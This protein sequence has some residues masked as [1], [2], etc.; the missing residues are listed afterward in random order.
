MNIPFY[1]DDD[2]I[3]LGGRTLDVV[4]EEKYYRD[5]F[6]R[7]RARLIHSPAFRR[8]RGKTQLFPN[9]DNDFFRCRLTHSL[10]V[11]TVAKTLTRRLN[12][13]LKNHYGQNLDSD[14]FI[15]EDLV[16][17]ACL[18]H[19]IGHPPFGH[20]GESLLNEKMSEFGGFEGNAQTLRIL[21]VLEKKEIGLTSCD[22]RLDYSGIDSEGQDL[23][24][25]LNLTSR[26]LAAILKYNRQIPSELDG[27]LE[28]GYYYHDSDIVMQIKNNVGFQDGDKQCIECQIM[29]IADDIAY[30]TY[31]LEDAFKGGFQ[32]PLELLSL[33]PEFYENVIQEVNT[34]YIC[35]T[36]NIKIDK[37]D[38]VNAITN[39]IYLPEFGKSLDGE[40]VK[41]VATRVWR[42]SMEFA[43]IG[44]LRN[45]FTS[46]AIS[47]F[48]GQISIDLNVDRPAFSTLKIQDDT[49][50]DIE[51]LKK[52]TYLSQIESTKLKMVEYRGQH[53]LARLFDILDS[54]SNRDGC[55][56]PNDVRMIYNRVSD[57]F[58]RKRILCDF[59]ASMTNRYAIDYIER[60]E[61]SNTRKSIFSFY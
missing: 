60:L 10:E 5:S 20:Q 36:K 6:A 3:R 56:L 26:S 58:Y 44:Y 42:S 13:E 49:I 50:K 17:F 31:D 54:K 12:W 4:G 7:D 24:F 1:T 22:D 41:D 57:D 51:I 21:S 27:K 33:N 8:L 59:I 61:S 37:E 48:I 15:N 35:E 18:A 55:L 30:S 40:S 16:E 25:G 19:D 34:S 38:I 46:H 53:L 45:R 9:R 28:K 2:H 14:Y 39:H 52:V 11:A 32:H 43:S 29:D 47:S 23:R